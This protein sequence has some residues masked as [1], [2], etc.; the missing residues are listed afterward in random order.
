MPLPVLSAWLKRRQQ[1]AVLGSVLAGLL[2]AWSLSVGNGG[3]G[4]VMWPRSTIG[5][6]SL[7]VGFPFQ[8]LEEAFQNISPAIFKMH[9]KPR[10]KRSGG[11][12]LLKTAPEIYYSK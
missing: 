9:I 10:C 8:I 6:L 12:R 3:H 2:I 1:A 7:T 4:A 11:E 5:T